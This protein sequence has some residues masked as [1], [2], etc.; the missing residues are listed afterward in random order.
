M[1]LERGI[2]V[3]FLVF[4][5]TYGYTAFVTMQ[6][7]LLPFELNMAFLPNTLPKALSVVG[8]FVA[9]FVIVGGRGPGDV[10]KTGPLDVGKLEWR[11]ICQALALLAAMAAYAFLLRPLGFI[12]STSLFLIGTALLLGERKI[13]RLIAISIFASF[14]VWYLVEQVLEIVLRPW[15]WFVMAQ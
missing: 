10:S 14:V 7:E 1:T 13:L 9:L 12:A 11:H 5:V 6:S 4:C 8:A 3:L 15:P 2:A